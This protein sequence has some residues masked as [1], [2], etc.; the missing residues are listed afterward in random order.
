LKTI[1]DINEKIRQ[2][3]VV[4]VTAEEMVEIVREKGRRLLRRDR[5]GDDRDIRPMCSS[6]MFMNLDT[7][8]QDKT[9][10]RIVLS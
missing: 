3:K 5:C 7:P 8:S 6:G 10:R 1:A 4:V 9:G 2:G